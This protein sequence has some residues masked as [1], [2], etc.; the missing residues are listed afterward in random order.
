VVQ[1][2]EE[3]ETID[4]EKAATIKM[5]QDMAA[6]KAAPVGKGLK[7]SKHAEK[8]GVDSKKVDTNCL[9]D[10][11]DEEEDITD[12]GWWDDENAEGEEGSVIYV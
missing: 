10:W 4:Q 1:L 9:S 7:G 3:K 2:R 11:E 5:R 6:A 12:G 8:Q